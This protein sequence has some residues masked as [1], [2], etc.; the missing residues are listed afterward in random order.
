M[1]LTTSAMIL[2]FICAIIG[3]NASADG[4]RL[5]GDTPLPDSS[6]WD[7][8][9]CSYSHHDSNDCGCSDGAYY[10]EGGSHGDGRGDSVNLG[11]TPEAVRMLKIGLSNLVH[12]RFCH[13][14]SLDP[15][16][17]ST[18]GWYDCSSSC[19]TKRMGGGPFRKHAPC[20]YTAP[21]SWTLLGVI[22]LKKHHWLGNSSDCDCHSASGCIS[23]VPEDQFDIPTVDED[24]Q[25]D[26]EN[27]DPGDHDEVLPPPVPEAEDETAG[28]EG[29]SVLQTQNRV[30]APEVD[31]KKGKGT[32]VRRK[33]SIS[34]SVYAKSH[35]KSKNDSRQTEPET[36]EFDQQELN[37]I[38]KPIRASATSEMP[39][40]RTLTVIQPPQDILSDNFA[41]LRTRQKLSVVL[42]SLT[43]SSYGQAS[44]QILE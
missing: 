29:S 37:E 21:T 11:C 38:T 12:G 32:R 36:L 30:L 27:Y 2:T 19:P 9:A 18:G 42:P 25:A 1:K 35:K 4:L 31:T 28:F 7:C 16:Y 22:P 41:E 10:D 40:P 26:Q 15:D 13:D 33:R 43:R 39:E 6:D 23:W 24:C 8:S 3:S 34:R 20:W 44:L 5:A 14:P 17:H